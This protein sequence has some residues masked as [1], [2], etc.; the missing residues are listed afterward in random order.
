MSEPHLQA[1][2][3][4]AAGTKMLAMSIYSHMLAGINPSTERQYN[5]LT[6]TSACKSVASVCMNSI[7]K[8][9]S[10]GCSR[11]RAHGCAL[12]G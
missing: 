5:T 9:D 11:P 8:K 4:S 7:T 10:K 1:F 12:L 2:C 6:K 3:Y